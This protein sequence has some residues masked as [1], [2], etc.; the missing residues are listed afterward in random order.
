LGEGDGDVAELLVVGGDAQRAGLAL[1]QLM[2]NG[3]R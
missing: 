1:F 2:I 3:T